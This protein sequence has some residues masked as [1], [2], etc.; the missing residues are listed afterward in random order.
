[1]QTISFYSYKGGVGRSLLLSNVAS[2]L[3]QFGFNV[4]VLDFDLE[5]P[6]LHHKMKVNSSLIKKG[7]LDYIYEYYQFDIVPATISDIVYDVKLIES[8]QDQGWVKL[9]P[10]GNVKKS[11][12][13]QNLA[14]INWHEFLFNPEKQGIPFF[15]DMKAR[16]EA[17]IKP[18]FLLIDSRTGV[19]EIGGICTTL[20]PN[21]LVFVFTNNEENF[22]GTEQIF[23]AVQK[24][25][26]SDNPIETHFV[27]TRIPASIT[28]T[29]KE[30]IL[31]H[32]ENIL[33]V[34]KDLIKLIYSSSNLET[35]EYLGIFDDKDEILRNSYLDVYNS[36]IDNFL[37]ENKIE[38][39][40][41]TLLNNYNFI[42]NFDELKEKLNNLNHIFPKNEKIIIQL[43][44]IFKI[45]GRDGM[46][47]FVNLYNQYCINFKMPPK[48]Y[49]L[50]EEYLKI[51]IR[52]YDNSEIKK[53]ISL[54]NIKKILEYDNKLQK[55]F[56]SKIQLTI[57]K[58][59]AENDDAKKTTDDLPF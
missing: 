30:E 37:L 14:N 27:L 46:I 7:L 15:Y 35:L 49:Q 24:V 22:E 16:I 10:A 3:T 42:D 33:G 54:H 43:L 31:I 13:W 25:S 47:D 21:K 20:F 4:C 57:T 11:A 6:G 39:F 51:F 1:M 23:K 18:D 2:Y 26:S 28:A 19:T 34:K 41:N 12:Y 48:N 44:K 5:A 45:M 56:S 38:Y 55:E 29:N 59:S 8:R 40:L 58:F 52:N 53:M 50:L 36:I 9:I 17:E 32:L